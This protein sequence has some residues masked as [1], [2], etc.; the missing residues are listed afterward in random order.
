MNKIKLTVIENTFK[1][2]TEWQIE[3]KNH[4]VKQKFGFN[5]PM[6]ILRTRESLEAFLGG[7][8]HYSY[9]AGEELE[10]EY[11]NSEGETLETTISF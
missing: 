1:T 2:K 3:A 6:A 9:I 5:S 7:F 10:I 4:G 11:E 8:S